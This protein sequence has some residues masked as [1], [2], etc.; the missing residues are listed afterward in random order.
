[1][2]PGLIGIISLL[3]FTG[4]I[5]LFGSCFA[6]LDEPKKE[7]TVPVQAADNNP[8]AVNNPQAA[9]ETHANQEI[10]APEEVPEITAPE[11]TAP[12]DTATSV[13]ERIPLEDLSSTSTGDLTN[14]SIV[15]PL[16]L[17]QS[18]IL[19]QYSEVGFDC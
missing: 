8:Q 16:P 9:Q 1:M 14:A 13:H 18:D 15:T 12:E 5:C 19:P 17:Y 6:I 11:D 10:A 4:A 2:E 3:S 7:R